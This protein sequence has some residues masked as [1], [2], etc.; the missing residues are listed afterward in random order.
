[1]KPRRRRR[2][3]RETGVDHGDA[4]VAAKAKARRAVANCR[5]QQKARSLAR[6][7]S[8]PG[9]RVRHRHARVFS[10]ARTRAASARRGSCA[11][12]NLLLPSTLSPIFLLFPL[13]FQRDT[14]FDPPHFVIFLFFEPDIFFHLFFSAL[15]LILI[16]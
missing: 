4:T 13:N 1:M 14:F 11:S 5:V 16:Y 7:S 2:K 9:T 6:S 12:A 10:S 3:R 15:F 8:A